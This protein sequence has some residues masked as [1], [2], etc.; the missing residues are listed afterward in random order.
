MH[1]YN[2]SDVTRAL[3]GYSTSLDATQSIEGC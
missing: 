1:Q 2:T 3:L